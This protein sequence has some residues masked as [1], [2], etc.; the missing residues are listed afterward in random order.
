MMQA[1]Q[2]RQ[3]YPESEMNLGPAPAAGPP[4]PAYPAHEASDVVLRSASTVRLRPIRLDDAPA[5][6]DFYRRL[7]PECLYLRFF[8]AVRMD[9]ARAVEICRIDYEDAFGFVAEVSCLRHPT[10]VNGGRSLH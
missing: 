7:S 8:G 6:V 1:D 2:P 5:L 3:L 4:P 10:P 9:E